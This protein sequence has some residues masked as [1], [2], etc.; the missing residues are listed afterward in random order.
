ME[1]IKTFFTKLMH[2]CLHM[3][4]SK[5]NN[6]FPLTLLYTVSVLM[7]HCI[8]KF[9]NYDQYQLGILCQEKGELLL[10]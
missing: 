9:I 6:L 4:V 3:D 10:V 5:V 2:T 1:K 7:F 8:I